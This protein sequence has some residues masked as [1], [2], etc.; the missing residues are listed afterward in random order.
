LADP[1]SRASRNDRLHEDK[2]SDARTAAQRD[3][4]RILYTSAFRRLAGVTQ[5]VAAD[6]GHVFHNRLT[7]SLEVAQFGRRLAEKLARENPSAVETLGG[8]DPDVV[9][10]A[11]LAHDLGHPP[12]GHVAE[13]QLNELVTKT[14][15]SGFEGNAQSFR[16]VTK[17]ALLSDDVPGLNLTRATLNAVLK[18]P[19]VRGTGGIEKLKWGAYQTEDVELNWARELMGAGNKQQSLE[20]AIM[21]WAD[22]VTYAVHD[23]TDFYRA[24]LIPLDRL[25]SYKDDSTRKYFFDEV[26]ERHRTPDLALPFPEREL[27]K[28]FEGIIVYFPIDEPYRG[29]RTQ[30]GKLRSVTAGLIGR[31]INAVQ[32]DASKHSVGAG[33][34]IDPER[35]RE[36]IMWKQLTWHYVILNPAL[37]TQQFGQRKIIRDLF[38]IF[39]DAGTNGKDLTVFPFAYRDQ[40]EEICSD[41]ERTV[42]AVADLVSGLTERQAIILH[43]RLTGASLGSVLDRVELS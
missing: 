7:H 12:F 2:P 40:L 33:L 39:V 19:W 42:R 5:V 20:A 30:R 3:R 32:L 17:L 4:D 25:A 29:T 1:A 22:D 18:Y 35:K 13:K 6:E 36:V 26:F 31:Y 11:C 41:G 27:E 10:A 34:V 9:E 21:D 15:L 43:R 24:G 38:E 14:V 8:I 16:I 37:T 23:A 28:A